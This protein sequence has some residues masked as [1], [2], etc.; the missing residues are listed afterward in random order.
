MGAVPGNLNQTAEP[1]AASVRAGRFTNSTRTGSRFWPLCESFAARSLT[2][3]P[4]DRL[5]RAI[6]ETTIEILARLNKR[7]LRANPRVVKQK[8]SKWPVKHGHQR[9]PAQPRGTIVITGPSL[10][11]TTETSI[12]RRRW[13]WILVK[14]YGLWTFDG[15]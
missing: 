11:L 13:A 14:L 2:R 9:N 15:G 10:Y 7:R 8:M 4:P 12:Y 1:E 6:A 3:R 5:T